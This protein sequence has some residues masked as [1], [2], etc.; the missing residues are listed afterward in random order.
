MEWELKNGTFSFLNKATRMVNNGSICF[1]MPILQAT[2][3]CNRLNDRAIS[4]LFKL[5]SGHCDSKAN[6]TAPAGTKFNDR[7][8]GLGNI[9]ADFVDY[10]TFQPAHSH[11]RI[12]DV[13]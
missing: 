4:K 8:D 3:F 6:A 7:H 11:Y 1:Y 10:S 9:G 2:V 12:C 13:L 5:R